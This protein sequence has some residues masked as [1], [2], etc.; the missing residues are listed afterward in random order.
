[1]SHAARVY[2]VASLSL[3]LAFV[4]CTKKNPKYCTTNGDCVTR[5]CNTTLHVCESADGGMHADASDGGDAADARDGGDAA[6]ADA[7]RDASDAGDGPF[8]C[9]AN[10]QCV[11]DGGGFDGSTATV[12]EVEAGACVDCVADSDCSAKQPRTPICQAHACRACK[13]DAE[14]PD[15]NICMTDGHCAT[16]DEVLFVEFSSAGC[17][18][19]D[20]SSAHPY[21]APN[22]AVAKL[23][24]TKH[25]IVIRGAT[26]NQ[27]SLG[28]SGLKPIV[29]G[30][31]SSS[32][33]DP[34]ILAGAATSIAVTSDDVLIRDLLVNLGSTAASKGIA[35]SGSTTLTLSNVQVKLGTGLGIQAD[36]GSLLTM[37]RCIVT[38][39]DAGGILINGA[40]YTIQNTI[41][42]ENMISQVQF[43]ATPNPAASSF[44]FNTVVA[45]SGSAAICDPGN[46]R[47]LSDSIV[48]GGQNC[49]LAN[50][51][52]TAPTFKSSTDYHLTAHLQCPATPAAPVPDH[53]IDGDPRTPPLDCGADQFQ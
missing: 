41:V 2:A 43:A 35:V 53:D 19:E 24:S 42:A 48:V 27:L 5:N 13:T 7:G 6:D 37:D 52:T 21:C 49:T 22:S 8:K 9:N 31:K 4:A 39:N 32:G 30:K 46:R 50:S 47:T 33:V 12:C 34:S 10:T 15:P 1:M 44:R 40:G 51:I 25:I 23:T 18:S 20:G 28:T 38:G 45:T 29:V 36:T 26:N 14:C 11:V 17:P 3:A 16:T